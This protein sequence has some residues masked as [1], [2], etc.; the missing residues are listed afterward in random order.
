MKKIVKTFPR[1]WSN[2]GHGKLEEVMEKVME[3][4]GTSKAQKSTNPVYL[5]AVSYSFLFELVSMIVLFPSVLLE[6]TERMEE[7]AI[8]MENSHS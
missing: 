2:L 8:S 4:H 7:G 6:V 1:K 3:S 5:Y